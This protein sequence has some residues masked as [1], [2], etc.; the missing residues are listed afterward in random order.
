[1][2][3]GN[4]TWFLLYFVRRMMNMFRSVRMVLVGVGLVM[5]A[6][7]CNDF[8]KKKKTTPEHAIFLDY[9]AW[10]DEDGAVVNVRLQ[11]RKGGPEGDAVLLDSPAAISWDGVPMLPDSSKMNGFYYEKRMPLAEFSKHNVQF[12]NE[13]GKKY[14]T[15][16]DFPVFKLAQEFPESLK[17]GELQIGLEGLESRDDLQVLLSDTSFY[18][19]GIDRIFTVKNGRLA[20]P[21]SYMDRLATGPVSMELIR[22]EH[23]VLP[24]TPEGGGM[25]SISYSVKREFELLGKGINRE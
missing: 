9:R 4:L 23:R 16:I 13:D 22:E 17:R 10:G 19:R 8:K 2:K 25:L 12:I 14:L 15:V 24:Q 5:M 7:A 18:G 6:G 11:F 20:I 21:A 1:M 3:Q